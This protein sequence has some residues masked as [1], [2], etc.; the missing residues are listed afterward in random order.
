VHNG[1][2]AASSQW[3]M[4]RLHGRW[5]YY[6]GEATREA[7]QPWN[8]Q[9]LALEAVTTTLEAFCIGKLWNLGWPIPLEASVTSGP[10]VSPPSFSNANGDSNAY[11]YIRT[12]DHNKAI[13]ST[14]DCVVIIVGAHATIERTTTLVTPL[15]PAG[16][17]LR[18]SCPSS[19]M[20]P[21]EM[22][23][24]AVG[25]SLYDIMDTQRSSL[26]L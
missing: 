5:H 15:L 19:S 24:C 1:I 4:Q 2:T 18:A 16:R 23:T 9:R 8:S 6:Y 26:F 11:A 3:V 10:L 21:L 14:D 25:S 22:S 20:H 13:I 17:A 7:E 12:S